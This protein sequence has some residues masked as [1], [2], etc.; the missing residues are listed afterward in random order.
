M[1]VAKIQHKTNKVIF[2][3][4]MKVGSVMF[5]PRPGWVLLGQPIGY[6]FKKEVFWKHPDD[7]RFIWVREFNF[8]EKT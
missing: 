6:P 2:A 8:K 7:E 3:E 1:I 4:V 5:D